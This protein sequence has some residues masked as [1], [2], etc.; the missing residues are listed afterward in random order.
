MTNS[1]YFSSQKVLSLHWSRFCIEHVLLTRRRKREP[2]QNILSSNLLFPSRLRPRVGAHRYSSL[3]L[4]AENLPRSSV[5]MNRHFRW[6]TL[7]Q[8]AS[9]GLSLRNDSAR[10]PPAVSHPPF[11]PMP[12]L[13]RLAPLDNRRRRRR[14]RRRW[15]SRTFRD[16]ANRQFCL[17]FFSRRPSTF[18][19]QACRFSP[20][21]K[22]AALSSPSR[23]LV[24]IRP[25]L[26]ASRCQALR[27]TAV[28]EP[29][30]L[31]PNCGIINEVLSEQSVLPPSPPA[32]RLSVASE[33][34][35]YTV[36]VPSGIRP[37]TANVASFV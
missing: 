18:H 25:C 34:H 9:Y 6:Q 7:R 16:A 23:A 22:A 12:L 20:P 30:E 14:R 17:S 5:E 21:P 32:E 13:R 29:L 1:L 26:F 10:A 15:G 2:L 36:F 4:R 24:L 19:R 27:V 3:F 11:T 33:A 28:F 37:P 35:S 8:P 31:F